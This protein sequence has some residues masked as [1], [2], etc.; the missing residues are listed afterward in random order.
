MMGK[1]AVIDHLGQLD[2]GHPFGDLGAK[3]I[4]RPAL[5]GMLTQVRG[6]GAQARPR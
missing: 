6:Q 4:S 2:R 5:D 3:R 1:A